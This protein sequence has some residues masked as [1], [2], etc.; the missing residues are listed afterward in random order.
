MGFLL[1]KGCSQAV[2]VAKTTN[3]PVARSLKPGWQNFFGGG[4]GEAKNNSTGNV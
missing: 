1:F 2:L 3:R 4:G